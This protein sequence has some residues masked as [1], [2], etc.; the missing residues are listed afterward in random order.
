M[1]VLRARG[2][3]ATVLSLAGNL[4]EQSLMLALALV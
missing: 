1:I 3:A 2:R 4:V